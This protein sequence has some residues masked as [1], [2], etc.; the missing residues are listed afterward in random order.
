MDFPSYPPHTHLLTHSNSPIRHTHPVN[1]RGV[2]G[3][4]SSGECQQ[5]YNTI[6]IKVGD[7]HSRSNNG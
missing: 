2:A 5:V 4:S 6:P 7:I 1:S 3:A